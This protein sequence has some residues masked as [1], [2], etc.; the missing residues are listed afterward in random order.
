MFGWLETVGMS[1]L[2]STGLVL[3]IEVALKGVAV[4]ALAGVATLLMWRCAAAARY[5]VWLLALVGLLVLPLLGLALPG[6]QILPRW[7]DPLAGRVVSSSGGMQGVLP[8][9]PGLPL[10]IESG[11]ALPLDQPMPVDGKAI[12]STGPPRSSAPAAPRVS[13]GESGAAESL[14]EES[15]PVLGAWILGLWAAGVALTFA[16]LSLGLLSLRRVG[17]RARRVTD[18]SWIRL[19]ERLSTQLDVGRS[20]QLVCSRRRCM[21]MTWGIFRAKLLLPEAALEW[22]ADRR[23]AALLHELAH[24]KRQDYLSQLI[25]QVVCALYWFNPLVWM[26]SR[27]IVA[28]RERSCDDLVLGAGSKASEYAEHLLQIASG[29]KN[30]WLTGYAAPAMARASKLEGR[31][32]AILDSRRSHRALSR[33]AQGLILLTVCLVVLPLATIRF[34]SGSRAAIGSTEAPAPTPAPPKEPGPAS[35]E[36]AK[37]RPTA[38]MVLRQVEGGDRASY[39][40]SGYGSLSPDGRYLSYGMFPGEGDLGV[41]ELDTGKERRLTKKVDG[42]AESAGGSIFS[43]DSKQVAYTWWNKDKFSE[44]RIVG[45]EESQPRVLYRNSEVWGTF[46][47]AWS[48]NGKDILG[49]F[50][51][52]GGTNQIGLV[53]VSDGSLRVLKSLDWRYPGDEMNFSPDG[54]YIVY[55]FPPKEES[56][57]RDIF[58][59]ASDGSREIPLVKHPADDYVLGWSPDGRWILFASERRGTWDAWAIE[60]ADGKPQGTPELVKLGIGEIYPVG[61][62]RN[63]TYYYVHWSGFISDIYTAMIDPATGKVLAEPTKLDQRMGFNIPLDWSADGQYLAYF[64]HRPTLQ[65]RHEATTLLIRSVDT[66]E[67]RKLSLR[68]NFAGWFGRWSPDGRSFMVVASDRK[69]RL[70]LYQVDAQTGKM[71]LVMKSKPERYALLPEWSPDGKT[72]FYLSRP[73]RGGKGDDHIVMRDLKTGREKELVRVG[74]GR[75]SVSPDGR[76]LAFISP[77]KATRSQVLKLMPVAGGETRELCRVKDPER[78]KDLVWTPDGRQVLFTRGGPS[79]DYQSPTELWRVSAEGGK[80]GRVDL[81]PMNFLDNVRV[82]PDGRRIAFKATSGSHKVEVWAMENFLPELSSTE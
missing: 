32:L 37:D 70:G 51:A 23:R 25:T 50:T 65:R 12:Q 14:Q 11:G 2:M 16:S 33:R 7:I 17:H 75:F 67:E 40:G 54:R 5:L 46:P 13:G 3:L 77:E 69:N 56:P 28:E 45:L 41:L 10:A 20:V 66:G 39:W 80:P 29:P 73:G 18:G 21:P 81:A 34:T 31:L 63:G 72:I 47:Y 52:K 48:P 36:Y 9:Q 26:A 71:T 4:L 15:A 57:Q 58:L 27:Q 8:E 19:L 6:W 64:S 60:V 53:S 61:F 74:G 1:T 35:A 82:H 42:S 76:W 78:M 62:T 43:P 68:L 79:R 30:K 49:V 55:D 22:S 24:V 44:L 38:G 59:L